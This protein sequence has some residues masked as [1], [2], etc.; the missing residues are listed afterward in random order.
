MQQKEAFAS[1]EGDHYFARNRK[2]DP[3]IPTVVSFFRPYIEPGFKVLEIGCSNGATLRA[4]IDGKG[5]EGFGIDPSAAAVGDAPPGLKLKVGT[6]D[7]LDYPGA[8]LDMVNF[9]FCLYLIDRPLLDT[10]ISEADRVLKPGGFLGIWDFDPPRPIDREY[11][12]RAGIKT[13][14]R[15]YSALFLKRPNYVLIAKAPMTHAGPGFSRDPQERVA[16]WLLHKS[17]VS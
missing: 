7:T 3:N 4:M 6:A 8:S 16:C 9:G 14:K 17:P 5:A 1:G 2:I 11:R 12:H 10:A 15:D 13:F